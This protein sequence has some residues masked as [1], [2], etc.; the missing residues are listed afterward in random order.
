MNSQSFITI[1]TIC[2]QKI[3]IIPKRK[4]NIY[5]VTP[6]FLSLQTLLITNLIFISIKLPGLDIL[7]KWN[8]TICGFL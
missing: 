1:I 7:Y 6:Y 4:L 3:F 8:P 2:F 5:Q